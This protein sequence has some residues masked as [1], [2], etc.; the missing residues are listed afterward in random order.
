MLGGDGHRTD[1][2]SLSD[3]LS[4]TSGI[5]GFGVE[6]FKLDATP[7]QHLPQPFGFLHRDGAD[8]DRSAGFVHLHDLFH[9][10]VPLFPF[11][12]EDHVG[13]IDASQGLVGGNGHDFEFVDFPELIGFGHGRTGHPGDFLVQT[14]EILQ[15]DSGQGL[16]FLF[17]GHTFFGL[18]G[19][20]QTIA[21]LPA[22]H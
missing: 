8:E 12:A 9:D 19:L 11:G 18:H 10:G 16:R 17:D 20:V 1:A 2:A 14:E 3:N 6:Q 15:G 22:N 5:F 21:P 4:F 7:P 13:V